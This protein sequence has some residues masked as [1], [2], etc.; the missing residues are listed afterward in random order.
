M[1]RSHGTPRGSSGLQ[2]RAQGQPEAAG[3]VCATLTVDL[4]G[5]DS[6]RFGSENADG[7]DKVQLQLGEKF[8]IILL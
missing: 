5:E 1:N 3:T 8:V 4:Q 7:E 6:L 2:Q